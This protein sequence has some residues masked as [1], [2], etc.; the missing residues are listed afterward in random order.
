MRWV[1]KETRIG[2]L[3]SK[4]R[5]NNE[6]ISSPDGG[7]NFLFSMSSK[8]PLGSTQPIKWVPG[9]KTAGA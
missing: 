4:F 6:Q 3:H 9:G 8:P 1:G 2:A 5:F 7:K